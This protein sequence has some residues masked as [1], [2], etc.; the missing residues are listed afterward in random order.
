MAG[1]SMINRVIIGLMAGLALAGTAA[2][3]N[4]SLAE[5]LAAASPEKGEKIF[6][7]CHACHTIDDGGA[8]GN[9]PNLW[10]VVGR[11]VASA[12]GFSKYSDALRA[13]GGIWSVERIDA[14]LTNP[15]ENIEGTRMPFIGL[16]QP[17]GRADLI[18]YLNWNSPARLDFSAGAVPGSP[19]IEEEEPEYGVFAVADGVEE[20]YAYCTACHSERLVAQQGLDRYDWIELLEWMVEEQSMAKIDEP[21]LS[22]VLDYLTTNYNIDRPNFPKR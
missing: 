15:H 5:R 14:F 20:A 22:I 9:G 4:H 8:H 7:R 11:P 21:D 6:K 12:E 17:H 13:T 18:A 16:D 3:D 19:P 10:G 1:V 2:A